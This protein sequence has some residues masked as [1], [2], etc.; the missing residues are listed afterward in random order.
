MPGAL[1]SPRARPVAAGL[2]VVAGLAVAACGQVPSPVGAALPPAS[3]SAR[4]SPPGA[5]ATRAIAP[6]TGLPA[7]SAADAARPAVALAVAGPSPRG[8]TAADVVFEEITSPVRYIAVYQSRDAAG[9]GPITTTEP[10]DRTA[11][12]VLRPIVGYDNAAAPYFI[13]LLDKSKIIDAG[14]S[15]HA[16]LYSSGTA[17]LTTSTRA[18]SRVAR[19]AA[20][21]Q[22]LFSYRG[23]GAGGSTLASKEFR[24]TSVSV[25]MPGAGTEKWAFN[26][27]TDRWDLTRNGPR[28]AVA[29]LVVQTVRYKQINVSQGIVVPIAE[30]TGNG[31]AEVFSGTVSGGSGGSCAVGTWSK[32]HVNELTNYF[33]STG[34]PMAFQPGPTWVIFAPPA[35]HVSTAGAQ[36]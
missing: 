4:S 8:L 1:A 15:G 36:G 9:V 2:A 32:P 26:Q 5:S 22:P 24:C 10:T 20:A 17:G 11:L 28:V 31:R 33:G 21:P 3:P 18:I 35:T 29:N 23:A 27:G 12:A 7:A 34:T 13:K 14:Y 25:A 19:G 30:I 16:S 6:L